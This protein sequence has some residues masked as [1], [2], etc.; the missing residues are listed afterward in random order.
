MLCCL[1]QPHS[2]Q[3]SQDDAN[4]F[5][6]LKNIISKLPIGGGDTDSKM[7]EADAMKAKSKAY[8]FNPDNVAPPEVQQQ[9]LALLKWRDGVYR[10]ILKVAIL[11]GTRGMEYVVYVPFL[12]T[13]NRNGARLVRAD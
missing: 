4:S 7:S 11:V 1:H 6:N 2:L 9:L 12:P 10:D 8:K 3:A 13:E 5:S